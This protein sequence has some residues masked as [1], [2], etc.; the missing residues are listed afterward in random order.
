MAPRT[1]ATQPATRMSEESVFVN[2]EGNSV[3]R[4]T[5]T[6]THT[7][8]NTHTQRET[9]ARFVLAESTVSGPRV[10]LRS[11]VSSSAGGTRMPSFVGGEEPEPATNGGVDPSKIGERCIP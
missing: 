10:A 4:H 6:H 2:R 11:D 1:R 9:I 3:K 7:H 5:H 8:T